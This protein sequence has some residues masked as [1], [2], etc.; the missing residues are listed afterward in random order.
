M[1]PS[2]PLDRPVWN[3]LTTRQAH[4]AMGDPV[5]ALRFVPEINVFGATP[6]N[7]PD[8]LTALGILTPR[9]GGVAIVERHPIVPPHGLIAMI[10]EP[11]HQMTAARIAEPDE[12]RGIIPLGDS[13]A[14]EMRALAELTQPG[15][16]YAR[17]HEMG[18]FVGIREN[19]R[20]IAMTG[21]RMRLPGFT[22]ISAVCTHPDA[23]GRGLA[24]KLMRVVAA[25]IVARGEQLFL[26]VYPHNKGAIAVYEK[27]G[28][29]HRAELRLTVLRH[30]QP[31]EN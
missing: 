26:H 18:D 23:R 5:T 21:E 6:D 27:L 16:F 1:E 8:Q 20:L 4:L 28:F 12:D 10:E 3:A 14:A 31:G 24:A 29:R 15:P 19:G 7:T 11:V 30:R 17:T 13:D 9:D 25:K 22:E 2:H